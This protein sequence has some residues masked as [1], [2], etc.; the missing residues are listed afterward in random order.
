MF[1]RMTTEIWMLNELELS[2]PFVPKSLSLDSREW[3]AG[4]PN[5]TGTLFGD[6][7]AELVGTVPEA[8]PCGTVYMVLSGQ[9]KLFGYIAVESVTH[10][11]F[12]LSGGPFLLLIR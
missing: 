3:F 1:S 9:Q 10:Y 4:D 6:G 11:L 2:I 12:S 7:V 8:K 5:C